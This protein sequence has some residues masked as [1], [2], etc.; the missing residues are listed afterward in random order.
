MTPITDWASGCRSCSRPSP[1]SRNPLVGHVLGMRIHDTQ[2]A[3]L[4][5][6]ELATTS[7]SPAPLRLGGVF[8]DGDVHG[9]LPIPRLGS[10]IARNSLD[11]PVPASTPFLA[12]SGRR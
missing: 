10:I 11:A 8:V 5:A 7:E 1:L 3:K 4:A 9:D 2:P 6:F 12:M